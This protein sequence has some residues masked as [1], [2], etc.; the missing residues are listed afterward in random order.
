M[1]C[2]RPRPFAHRFVPN[3]WW[4][5]VEKCSNVGPRS[6]QSWRGHTESQRSHPQLG[7]QELIAPLGCSPEVLVRRCSSLHSHG[8]IFLRRP[9]DSPD[10]HL[11]LC[12]QLAG[13][14]NPQPCIC[15]ASLTLFPMVRQKH[16]WIPFLAR[17][18]PT[19]QHSLTRTMPSRRLKRELI[20]R[21]GP[22]TFLMRPYKPLLVPA[23]LGLRRRIA[24]N[25]VPCT[26]SCHVRLGISA[27]QLQLQQF[28]HQELRTFPTPG[29]C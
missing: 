28:A 20:W 14:H 12:G 26:P 2:R 29:T 25:Q 19:T 9:R 16:T 22:W 5:H 17:P 7:F 27:G 1:G 11:D 13:L 18:S 10:L 15:R 4:P 21:P 23:L 24:Q 6:D 3:V 8:R